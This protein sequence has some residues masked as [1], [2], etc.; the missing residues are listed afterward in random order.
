MQRRQYHSSNESFDLNSYSRNKKI[1]KRKG[2]N[3]NRGLKI[4]LIVLCSV[5]AVAVA[6]LGCG[7]IYINQILNNVNRDTTNYGEIIDV[8]SEAAKKFED[9]TNIALFGLDTRTDDNDGRSDAIIILT[10]D[11]VHNKLKLTSIARDTLV[12]IDGHADQKITHAWMFG[13][14]A[15]ALDTINQNFKMNI[16]EYVSM[17]FYQFA[18]VIDY[19]GG[20]W[21]DVNRS[22][23]KVMNRDYIPYIK[24]M[25]IKCEKVTKTGYQLLTGGQALAYS[26]DRYTGTDLDRAARQREVLMAMFDQVKE[27]DV[28]K[29]PDLASM[30]LKECTTTLSNG[31]MIDMATWTLM[32]NPTFEQLTLPDESC[33]AVGKTINTYWV[34]VYDLDY[35]ADRLHDFI[36]EEGEFNRSAASSSSSVSSSS[37]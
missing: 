7:W 31:E 26:R 16:T 35:A 27:L 18:E 9:Y 13:K 2:G 34:W 4:F 37:K 12:K 3:K 23:M 20:V 24:K 5:L 33:K 32:N 28:K 17:N 6:V 14:A 21:I 1:K 10:I 8:N 11:R 29:L 19:I 15:L 36:L 30:V 25:G 22:E